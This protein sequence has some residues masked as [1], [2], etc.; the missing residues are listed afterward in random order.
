M[1][2]LSWRQ[3]RLN[4]AVIASALAVIA[5][6]LLTTGPD[7]ADAYRHGADTFFDRINL[8]RTQNLY[9]VGIAASY[10]LPAAIGAFWGAPLVARELEAGT[11][12]LAWTQSVTRNRWLATRLGF[13]LLGA[14]V[15]G[16]ALSLLTTWWCGPIDDTVIAN[17][18]GPGIFEVPRIAPTM[19]A[20]RG[21]VPIGYA[22]LAFVLGVTAGALIK[23]TVPAMAVTVVLYVVL[24]IAM[25]NLVRPHL[26]SP[27]TSTVP[28]TAETLRGF[29][30]SPENGV[31]HLDVSSRQLGGWNLSTDTVDKSGKVLDPLPAWVTTE[32]A[33]GPGKVGG[34]KVQREARPGS[35]GTPACIDHMTSAGLAQRFTSQPASHYWA[36]QWRETGLLAVGTIALAGVCF[37]RVR[38]LS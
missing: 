34:G 20:A 24:Q 38:R 11:H 21:I 7:L 15:A 22:A 17:G 12:R 14:V 35:P 9:V 27:T 18:P 13:G 4:L 5:I 23:R 16:G 29:Q 8:D 28:I 32:C 37:G 33:P 6:V 3:Q 19:F 30:G 36:L 26:V 2:W 1:I 10:A 31:E 25:P